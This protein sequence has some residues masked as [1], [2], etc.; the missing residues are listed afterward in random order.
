MGK[1]INSPLTGV[2]IAT[3]QHLATV[4]GSVVVIGFLGVLLYF[5]A[6]RPFAGK[7][8]MSWVMST[9]GFGIVL[10]S[11]G[12]AVWGP[13]QVVVPSVGDDVIRFAGI[14]VLPQEILM[15]VVA[16]II[17]IDLTMHRTMI[18]KA[19]HAVAQDRRVASL[20]GINVTVTRNRPLAVFFFEC[21]TDC[22]RLEEIRVGQ[23]LFG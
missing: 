15:F 20:M 23:P 10:T 14:G 5:L 9:I 18:G 17:A 1:P 7:P 12:L 3:W 21:L 11:L 4:L 22:N 13:S 19:M 6:V 16:V 2:N 8:G